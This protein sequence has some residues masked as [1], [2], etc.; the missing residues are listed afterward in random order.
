MNERTVDS[1][2]PQDLASLF[3]VTEGERR[4]WR[5]E[6]LAPILR[7]QLSTPLDFDLRRLAYGNPAATALLDQPITGGPA[8]FASLF[9]D[10]KAPLELLKLAKSFAKTADASSNPLLPPPIA[11]VIYYAAI[12]AARLRHNVQISNLPREKLIGGVKWS[13]KQAWLVEPL[14]GLFAEGLAHLTLESGP[15]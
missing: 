6:D 4:G 8:N 1:T 10:A 5:D 13:M 9:A 2:N 7:H 12:I 11:T 3:E 14:C 15:L